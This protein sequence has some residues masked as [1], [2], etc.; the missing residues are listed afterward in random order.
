MRPGVAA[1]TLLLL[2]GCG[3]RRPKQDGAKDAARPQIKIGD[4]L[5]CNKLI[6]SVRPV[7]PKA[8]RQKRIEGTVTLRARITKAGELREIT[9]V[10][11]DPIFVPEA[12]R[13]VK[14]WRYTPCLI[15]SEPVE[16]ITTFDIDFNL[17][18]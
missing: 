14:Q 3:S 2:V 11:G 6:H 9:V 16:V 5:N 8:A 15:D 12:V 1:L 13:V 4:T 10:K 17:S 7:Y 18:Q